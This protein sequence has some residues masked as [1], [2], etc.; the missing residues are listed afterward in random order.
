MS[1][2][3]H[4]F[5]YRFEVQDL[6]DRK[7]VHGMA[8]TIET[9]S[10]DVVIVGAGPSGLI[11]AYGLQTAGISTVIIGTFHN[12]PILHSF[13]TNHRTERDVKASLP[14]YGRACTLYPRTLEMLDQYGLL[15]TMNQI[16]FIARDSATFGKDGKRVTTR[17]WHSMYNHMGSTFLDYVL[18]I[19]LKYSE[20]VF[21]EAYEKRGG[22]ILQGW[23]VTDLQTTDKPASEYPVG[24]TV[25]NCA[26]KSTKTIQG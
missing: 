4:I 13:I 20:D 10:Y 9:E 16:G 17:G 5:I 19:R 3:P 14:M 22:K 7:Q 15:E 23:E 25:Q 21:M 12:P 6:L 18:N 11:S 1:L 24:V 2:K 26:D 8:V